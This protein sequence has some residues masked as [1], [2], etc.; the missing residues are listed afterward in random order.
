MSSTLQRLFFFFNYLLLNTSNEIEV[1]I[2]GFWQKDI[3][4][5][6]KVSRKV[7]KLI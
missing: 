4:D 1:F 7:K 3:S 6:N 2:S 5:I